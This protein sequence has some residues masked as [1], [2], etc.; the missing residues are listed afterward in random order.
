MR[1]SASCRSGASFRDLWRLA[2][3]SLLQVTC[4]STA[5]ARATVCCV[6]MHS[7]SSELGS[8][9]DRRRAKGGKDVR[10]MHGKPLPFSFSPSRFCVAS[11]PPLSC[12][13]LALARPRH[14]VCR[15]FDQPSESN[16]QPCKAERGTSG[17]RAKEDYCECGRCMQPCRVRAHTC[18]LFG[19]ALAR[20]G[21]GG[22]PLLLRA[23]ACEAMTSALPLHTARLR[24]G[25]VSHSCM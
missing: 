13:A 22:V 10:A 2:A 7:G 20:F 24:D 4:I 8:A 25:P 23:P 12:F 16:R 1:G 11:M 5:Q 19:I 18:C 17:E 14:V 9:G 21:C 3:T 15:G 6:C